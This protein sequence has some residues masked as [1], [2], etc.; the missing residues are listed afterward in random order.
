LS[1][2]FYKNTL[3]IVFSAAKVQK[4]NICCTQSGKKV[5]FFHGFLNKDRKKGSEKAFEYLQKGL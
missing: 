4:I 1:F 5:R 3:K 2:S